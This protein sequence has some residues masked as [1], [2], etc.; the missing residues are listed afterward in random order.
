VVAYWTSVDAD[1][2][3]RVAAGLRTSNGTGDGSAAAVDSSVSTGG[4]R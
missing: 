2:G 1:L 3:A 4:A